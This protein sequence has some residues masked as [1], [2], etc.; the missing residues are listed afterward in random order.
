MIWLGEGGQMKVSDI[1]LY[2]HDL[3]TRIKILYALT[4]GKDAW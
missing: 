2:Q 1:A 3:T 4:L